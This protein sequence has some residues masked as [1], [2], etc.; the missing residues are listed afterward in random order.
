MINNIGTGEYLTS[1]LLSSFLN[2]QIAC[3]H[4]NFILTLMNKD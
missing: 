2:F 1:K 3:I 4:A